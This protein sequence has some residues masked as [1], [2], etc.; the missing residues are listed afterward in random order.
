MKKVVKKFKNKKAICFLD[1]IDIY[2]SNILYYYGPP[3]LCVNTLKKV[4]SKTKKKI[5]NLIIDDMQR[6]IGGP[7]NTSDY[8]CEEYNIDGSQ[9]ILIHI[10]DR[11]NLTNI[12]QLGSIMH[13]C[14]HAAIFIARSRGIKDDNNGHE[15]LVYL[16]ESIFTD[17]LSYLKKH[18][19]KG[20]TN[21][22]NNKIGSKKGSKNNRRNK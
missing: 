7:D 2:C 9:W 6:Y 17:F 1:F 18:Y 19:L 5:R 13:E 14:L 21:D 15:A 3:N 12:F 16:A 8:F 10:G 22:K 4:L 11:Y 20:K